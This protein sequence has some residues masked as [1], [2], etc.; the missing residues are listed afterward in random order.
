MGQQ[1]FMSA[2][3]AAHPGKAEVQIAALQIAVN[4]IRH[5]RPPE[6][7][8][9]CVSIIPEA[10]QLFKV[11]LHATKITAGLRIAGPIGIKIKM[12]RCLGSTWSLIILGVAGMIA[13]SYGTL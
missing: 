13:T 11:V 4:R 1:V 9:R 2:L 6:P 12:L 5:I 8:P 3:I 7:I 10:F